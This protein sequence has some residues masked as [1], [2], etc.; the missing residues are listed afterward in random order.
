[1]QIVCQFWIDVFL[2][3]FF[4]LC[5]FHCDCGNFLSESDRPRISVALRGPSPSST[6][7]TD[8]APHCALVMGHCGEIH[9]RYTLDIFGHLWTSLDIFGHLWTSLDIFGHLWTSLDIFGHLWTSDF[10]N[11]EKRVGFPRRF[12]R[13]SLAP[14]K[15]ITRGKLWDHWDSDSLSIAYR[16]LI[17]SSALWYGLRM[18]DVWYD[19]S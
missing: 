6:S 15:N 13:H 10:A 4:S 18:F 2:M 1:M 11:L 12:W 19:Q 17:D 5:G 14:E 7:K 3:C 16:Q 9:S 8:T